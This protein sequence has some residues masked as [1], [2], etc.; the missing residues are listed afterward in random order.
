MSKRF[1]RITTTLALVLFL[2]GLPDLPD[3]PGLRRLSAQIPFEQAARDLAST[4]SGARLKATRMLKEA[5]YPEAA[6]PLAALVTDPV[7]DVQLEAIAAALNIFLT[8]R[9]V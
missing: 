5:A 9:I 3:L 6:V 7:D 4:D 8:E 1:W 2:P